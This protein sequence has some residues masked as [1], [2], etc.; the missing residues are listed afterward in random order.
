M[1]K[2]IV[3]IVLTTLLLALA[4]A[5]VWAQATLAKVE[6]KITDNGKP[7]PDASVT[8]SSIS[9]GKVFKMKTDKH[10]DYYGIGLPVDDYKVEVNSPSGENLFTINRNHVSIEGG[11][12]SLLNIDITKDRKGG[13]GQPTYTKEQIEAIKAQNAKATSLNA[14]IGQAQNAMNSRNW[15]DAIAPLQQMIEMDPKR[16][17]FYQA[18]GNSQINL[19][20]YQDA[21]DAYEKGMST[22]KDTLAAADPKTDAAKVKTG[23]GQMLSAEGNAYVKMGKND[24]AIEA[25]SKA[26]EMDPNPGT[27]YFN[28]C[29]TQY[30]LGQMKAAEVACTKAIAAD[31]NKADAYFIKGSAMMGDAKLDANNKLILPPGTAEVLN[32][33]LELAPDGAHANDVKA[34]LQA[35][36]A[37]IET[38]FGNRKKKK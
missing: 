7:V 34:M 2:N 27:A 12:A 38:S 26:A 22:A 20:H 19:S 17:E 11:A 13:T 33:Y 32:K 23:M 25:F 8:F 37:K 18:L 36:D 30:N 9:T 14:L 21:V 31:P 1:K 35:A 15:Q 10:G 6:G 3:L 4:S 28:L 29:A 5:P 24:L 16:W